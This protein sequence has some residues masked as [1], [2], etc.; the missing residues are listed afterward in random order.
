MRSLAETVS[1]TTGGG[2]GTWAAEL[3]VSF[4]FGGWSEWK[5]GAIIRL[6]FLGGEAV[7]PRPAL[8][9]AETDFVSSG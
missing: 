6:R 1:Y 8:L 9:L 3:L 7:M 2:G 5:H 4:G